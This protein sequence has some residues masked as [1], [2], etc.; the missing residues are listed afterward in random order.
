MV[1]SF[2]GREGWP[3]FYTGFSC[4][5]IYR[6]V[7]HSSILRLGPDISRRCIPALNMLERAVESAIA[8]AAGPIQSTNVAR[9]IWVVAGGRRTVA[10]P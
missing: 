4:Q 8:P 5:S 6:R 2:S 1:V 7:I 3:R 9:D 10:T